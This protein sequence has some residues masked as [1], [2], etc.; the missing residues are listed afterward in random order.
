MTKLQEPQNPENEGQSKLKA[1]L[2]TVLSNI[3]DD[4]KKINQ[5]EIDD[6][7]ILGFTINF[8]KEL[9]NCLNCLLNLQQR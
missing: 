5:G 1:Q 4:L 6:L 9:M 7:R 2:D 8:I 3:A